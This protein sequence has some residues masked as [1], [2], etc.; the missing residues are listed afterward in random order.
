[1][2]KVQKEIWKDVEGYDG[3]YQISTLGN[4][5]SYAYGHARTLKP[6]PNELGYLRV[7]LCKYGLIKTLRVHRLVA[8]AFMP[9][10]K[11]KPYINHIDFDPSNN[12]VENLEWCT[13]K[14]N[15]RHCI[16]SGRFSR[17]EAHY[18]SILKNSDVKKIRA[19]NGISQVQL[20]KIFKVDQS[21][22]SNIINRKKWT[23][24]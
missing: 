6:S 18:K 14:E 22:I 24:I 4:V 2:S 10:P 8:E 19:S 17:G 20:G 1:M 5:R 12:R 3:K 15:M 9:N 23:H 13:Q 16:D 7:F 21:V 11:N